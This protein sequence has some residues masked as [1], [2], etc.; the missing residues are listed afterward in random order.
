MT[1]T[2][3]VAGLALVGTF[4]F[5]CAQADSESSRAPLS[6]SPTPS[7]GPTAIPASQGVSAWTQFARGGNEVEH[8]SSFG[9]LINTADIVFVGT[10]ISVGQEQLGSEREGGEVET[11]TDVFYQIRVD[12]LIAGDVVST[13]QDGT[14]RLD[15]APVEPAKAQGAA[16]R[17]VGDQALFIMRRVG[18]DVPRAAW[19]PNTK[20]LHD[21]GAFRLVS[22][23]GLID[24]VAGQASFV[25]AEE[26]RD[27][28]MRELENKSFQDVIQAAHEAAAEASK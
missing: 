16:A 17:V 4:A 6:V 3:V 28:W 5:G 19:G 23:Q 10:V 9:Q 22:S 25:V 20:R 12:D 24:D 8:A 14:I 11:F 2:R 15:F 7:R 18:N 26:H 27:D 1:G 21:A 13:H